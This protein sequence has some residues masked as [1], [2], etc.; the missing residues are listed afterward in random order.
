[1]MRLVVT[2]T[3]LIRKDKDLKQLNFVIVLFNFFP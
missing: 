1:M 2:M 3:N